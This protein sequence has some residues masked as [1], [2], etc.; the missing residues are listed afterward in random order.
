MKEESAGTPS[1]P[2][3]NSI[4]SDRYSIDESHDLSDEE[5]MTDTDGWVYGDNK[6]EGQG[7]KG[8]I[9]KYTR[10]RRWTRVAVVQETVQIVG[11]G[12]TGI[13]HHRTFSMWEPTYTVTEEDGTISKRKEHSPLRQRLKAL[14]KTSLNS[15]A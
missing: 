4:A 9:G 6:W 13:Q 1:T 15:N 2:R 5:P 12:E 14:T 10:Y 3:S 8:G 11:D 7:S